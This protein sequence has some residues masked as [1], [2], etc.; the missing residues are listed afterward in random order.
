MLPTPMAS[1]ADGG[2]SNRSA[3]RNAKERL[4]IARM[5]ARGILPTPTVNGNNNRAGISEK[6]G[7]GLATAVRRMYLTPTVNDA[8][9]PGPV[10]V[11][12]YHSSTR[13]RTVQRLRTQAL[14]PDGARLTLNPEFVEWLMGFPIGWTACEP[15]E[16]PSSP[17]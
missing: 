9:N 7:D 2:S 12:E 10:E 16:T 3:H 6:A 1:D 4:L 13:R 5:V 15:S 14:G 11:A 8:K 17:P